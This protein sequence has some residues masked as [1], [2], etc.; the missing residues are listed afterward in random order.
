MAQEFK[1]DIFK[2]KNLTKTGTKELRLNNNIPGIFYAHNLKNSVPFY[3][4][5]DTLNKAKKSGAR[6][7]NINVEN[8]KQTVIFKSTQYHP[9]TDQVIHVDLYGVD[10]KQAVVVKIQII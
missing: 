4:S 3:M 7:F 8:E 9:V 2:R 10:M 1:L 5:Q 6:I